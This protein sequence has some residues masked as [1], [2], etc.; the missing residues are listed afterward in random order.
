MAVNIDEWRCKLADGGEIR[1][2][3]RDI[4][5]FRKKNADKFAYVQKLS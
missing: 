4:I 3:G 5:I 2:N 1:V